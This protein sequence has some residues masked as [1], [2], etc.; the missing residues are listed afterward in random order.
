MIEILPVGV[1][2]DHD[3]AELQ[4]AHAALEL[5]RRGA[6]VLHG[7]VGKAGI[8]V[9]APGDFAGQEVV[10]RARLAAG[11]PRVALGL[12]ARPGQRKDAALDAGP[13]HGGEPHLAEV[14]EAREEVV[15]LLG[16]QV[17]DRRRP[18]IL[19]AGTEAVLFDRDL[20]DHAVLGCS[21]PRFS[22]PYSG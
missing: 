3:A 10:R 21:S 20:P 16:R 19:E 14:G 6:G 1:A 15:P 8:A 4:L 2:V 7:K 9:G 5:V 11:G 13:I 18:I 22:V 17:D 12:H